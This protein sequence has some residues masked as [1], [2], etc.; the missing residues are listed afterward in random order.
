MY[1]VIDKHQSCIF[2]PFLSIVNLIQ[3]L[4][5]LETNYWAKQEGQLIETRDR[6]KDLLHQYK[7]MAQ[8]KNAHKF[9]STFLID[10][11]HAQTKREL[12]H[13]CWLLVG[14]CLSLE[15]TNLFVQRNFP[16]ACRAY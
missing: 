11:T 15:L 2:F 6:V 4:C 16:T 9:E 7:A 12:K 5:W 14:S 8:R 1:L 10:L 13:S 3:A